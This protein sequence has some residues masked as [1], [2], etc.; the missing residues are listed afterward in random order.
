[1]AGPVSNFSIVVESASGDTENS[2]QALN[3]LHWERAVWTL[4]RRAPHTISITVPAWSHHVPSDFVARREVRLRRDD[5]YVSWGA[6][7]LGAVQLTRAGDDWQMELPGYGNVFCLEFSRY[8]A[9]SS[10]FDADG[11]IG[12]LLD[13]NEHGSGGDWFPSA[14]R[15]IGTAAAGTIDLYS[16]V[17]KTGVAVLNEL[18]DIEGWGW[19]A[20]IN[21]A[22]TFTMTVNG[23]VETDRSSTIHAIDGA[24]CRIT[25]VTQD[26]SQLLSAIN[27]YAHNPAYRSQ[28]NG[29]HAAGATTITVDATAGLESGDLVDFA[30]GTT[31]W[32]THA[33][34]VVSSSTQFTITGGG[35][36]ANQAD[37]V[38]VTLRTEEFRLS[39][40]SAAASVAQAHHQLVS[41]QF[42][43]TLPVTTLRDE[44]AGRY[45]EVYDSV[46]RSATVETT[47]AALIGMMLDAGLEPGDS[48]KLTSQ[49]RLLSAWYSGTTVKVHE[50]AIELEPGGCRRITLQVGDPRL[51]DLATVERMVRAGNRAATAY[52]RTS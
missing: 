28:L 47:D 19:R 36:L 51:D 46:L 49:H 26:D 30:V 2:T 31:G 1:M 6:G 9:T 21:S 48:I 50:M 23:T 22:G 14:Q 15:T 34:N 43:D 12:S 39:S 29:S 44:M 10:G 17:G 4:R 7:F 38:N 16:A 33:V 25:G 24:N 45:Q 37:N 8:I 18:A 41:Y 5:V 27:L 13:T 52:R 11:L 32:E 3:P 42:D 40:V 20:G 35:L